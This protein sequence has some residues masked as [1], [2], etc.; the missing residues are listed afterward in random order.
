MAPKVTEAHVEARRH[1]ILEAAFICFAREGFHRTTMQDICREAEL[2]PGAVY[3][4]FRSKE[5]IIETSC[6]ES[7]QGNMAFIEEV[8]EQGDT[9]QLLE[10]L[11]GFAF[12]KL[13]DDENRI[14]MLTNIQLYG[15]ALRNPRIKAHLMK[16]GFDGWIQ[17]LSTIFR[18]AQERGEVDPKLD[19]EAIARVM[20]ALW[21]GLLIQKGLEPKVDVDRYAK[22]VE[23][24]YSG[25][26]WKGNGEQVAR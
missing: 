15:E 12:G 11:L 1:Q 7:Q 22:V 21:H 20:V 10:T 2:S 6:E 18:R 23:A 17:S 19:P 3:S 24:M 26:F 25:F 16:A 5:E 14:A 4:Y 9:L 13:K 8:M